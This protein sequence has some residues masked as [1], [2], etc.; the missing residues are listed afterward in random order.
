M[1]WR[2]RR[3]TT[4]VV[5]SLRETFRSQNERATQARPL[6]RASKALIIRTARPRADNQKGMSPIP[7]RRN[8]RISV[9]LPGR[10]WT[11]PL[12]Q[13]T[14]SA[15]RACPTVAGP[16]TEKS[17]VWATLWSVHCQDRPVGTGNDRSAGHTLPTQVHCRTSL[18]WRQMKGI[19]DLSDRGCHKKEASKARHAAPVDVSSRGPSSGQSLSSLPK[20]PDF[21][22]AGPRF[23]S[24]VVLGLS[25]KNRCATRANH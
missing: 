1:V 17:G 16:A 13:R 7:A 4:I 15:H 10:I 3:P 23:L 5:V 21:S 14:S 8:I 24:A 6:R 12:C 11:Y 20:P 19:G 22:V 9:T 18:L 25:V 2:G